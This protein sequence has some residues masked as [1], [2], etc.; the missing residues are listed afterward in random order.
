MFT[1]LQQVVEGGE[2]LLTLRNEPNALA[3]ETLVVFETRGSPSAFSQACDDIGLRILADDEIDFVDDENEAAK[4][5]YYLTMPDQRAISELLRLWTLWDKGEELGIHEKWAKVFSCLHDLRRWGPADRV[6]EEDA[7]T[8]AEDAQLAPQAKVRLEIELAFDPN[9]EKAA[10][11]RERVIRA[12]ELSDGSFKAT[13]RISEIAYDALL[14]D[15]TAAAAQQ[16]AERTAASLAGLVEV[17]AIRP[18]SSLKIA[19]AIETAASQVPAQVVEL[20]APIAALL[21]A[22]PQQNHTLLRGRLLIDDFLDLEPQAVGPRVH[23]TAMASLIVHGD[24]AKRELPISRRL[25]VMP[26]MYSAI[27]DPAFVDEAP[28]TDLLIVDVLV[29]AVRRLKVGD[30]NNPPVGPEVLFIN[31][32]IGD[33]KRPFGTRIS[34]LARALDWLAAK[35]GLL[36]LV[37]A[38]NHSSLVVGSMDAATYSSSVGEA[39]TRAT[40]LG[41]SWTM[42]GRRLLPPSEAMNCL[43]IGALHDDEIA[44]APDVGH[45]RDPL[46]V[47]TFANPVSRMGLGYRNSAKPDLLLPGGRLRALLRQLQPEV[48]SLDFGGPNRLGG[49][50]A[51]GPGPDDAAGYQTQHSGSTSGATALATRACHLVYDELEAAYGNEFLTLPGEA[52]AVVVKSLLVHRASIPKD[53]RS[54]IESV[55]GPQGRHGGRQRTA[56]VLRHFGFG[57][58]DIDEVLGCVS[59]RATL[60]ASGA[61]GENDG[62]LFRLPLPTCLSGVRC[63]R[64]VSVTLAWFTPIQAG[65]RAYK[66]VRLKVEEPSFQT[67]CSK[68]IGGQADRKPRGTLYHRTWEG[69][70]ARNFVGGDVLEL[71][72]ARDPDQGDE[73][74]DVITF[75]LAATI[76]TEDGELPIYEEVRTQLKVQ[77]RVPV[78]VGV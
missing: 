21:D 27:N 53:S 57:I 31:L 51:A 41:L 78:R 9:D 55:F 45:S 38:G 56:N 77:P 39:R 71:R 25:A 24:L 28:P 37:S 22:V 72:V 48:A 65:R 14:V 33:T 8:I 50:L 49:L 17:F 69:T 62:Q 74:P 34:A 68:A 47:G 61:V 75:G 15:V 42:H 35:H 26:I 1:R 5:H 29:R 16:V 66:G 18:Q 70:A 46:P 64:R 10:I 12:L 58:P 40:L 19:T 11:N 30:A 36:F 32:S 3:P 52:R 7:A 67:V 6:T 4:G 73:V 23:G 20:D 76:E 44:A 43:T 13:S 2:D 54:L 60:W 63:V 59:S